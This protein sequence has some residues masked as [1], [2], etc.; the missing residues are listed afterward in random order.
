MWVAEVD[1]L[2]ESGHCTP[3]YILEWRLCALEMV[4]HRFLLLSEIERRLHMLVC[5]RRS[6][7]R[8]NRGCVRKHK[9]E[10]WRDD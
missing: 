7:L 3:G 1:S 8:L 10:E 6:I 2:S 4:K 9:G 5:Q